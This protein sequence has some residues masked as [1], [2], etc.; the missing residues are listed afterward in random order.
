ME[1]KKKKNYSEKPQA[2]AVIKFSSVFSKIGR[3]GQRNVNST[4]GDPLRAETCAHGCPCAVIKRGQ[5]RRS[6][7]GVNPTGQ[8]AL[9]RL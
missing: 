9:R 6:E 8:A 3:P 4:L 7:T 2:W 5:G 1:K